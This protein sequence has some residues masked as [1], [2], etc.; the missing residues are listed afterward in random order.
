MRGDGLPSPGLSQSYVQ[1]HMKLGT[2]GG[3]EDLCRGRKKEFEF[4]QVLHTKAVMQSPRGP[5]HHAPCKS[6]LYQISFSMGESFILVKF[7]SSVF[8]GF[9]TNGLDQWTRLQKQAKKNLLNLDCCRR[10]NFQM[11]PTISHSR[12]W[13]HYITQQKRCF[14]CNEGYQ[15]ANLKKDYPGGPDLIICT[16]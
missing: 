7:L 2:V 6:E 4:Q 11:G 9:S 15:S 12:P 14:R 10:W 5:A 13:L 16:L 1:T 8:I 3:S